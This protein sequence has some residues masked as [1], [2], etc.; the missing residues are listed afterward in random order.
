M[1]SIASWPAAAGSIPAPS[2]AAAERMIVDAR[3]KATELN[4]NLACAVLDIRGDVVAALRMDG[5]SFLNMGVAMAK[6]RASASN[7]EEA[8]RAGITAAQ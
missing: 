7:D 5:A 8:A 4:I 6:A 2:G 1:E 3:A